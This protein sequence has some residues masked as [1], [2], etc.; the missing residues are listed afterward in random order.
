M[1]G[2]LLALFA[3]LDDESSCSK[4]DKRVRHCVTALLGTAQLTAAD[5]PAPL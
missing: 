3:T 5:S 4:Y 2:W 1:R